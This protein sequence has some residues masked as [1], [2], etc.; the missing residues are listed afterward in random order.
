MRCLSS[1]LH[2][3]PMISFFFATSL[4]AQVV[5][6]QKWPT[7]EQNDLG[8][9]YSAAATTFKVWAPLAKQA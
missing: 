8:I 6:D 9:T 3:L 4:F 2:W 5:Q 7:Y 1:S